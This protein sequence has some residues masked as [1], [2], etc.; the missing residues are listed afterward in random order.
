VR[1]TGVL[2]DEEAP[3]RWPV[4]AAD[5]S[6]SSEGRCGML[7]AADSVVGTAVSSRYEGPVCPSVTVVIPTANRA[8]LLG[9]LFS[10][11]EDQAYPADR[12]EVVVVDDGSHD[13]TWEVLTAAV[14]ETQMRALAVRLGRNMGQGEARNVGA[15]LA[16]GEVLAFTDDDC[17]PSA[18]WLSELLSPFA[19]P[20]GAR[21][22]VQGRTTPWD[23]DA[24]DAGP[25]ARTVWVLR[26]TWLFETCN[27]AYRRSDFIDAGGFVRRHEVPTTRSG[28]LIGEDAVLGWR[29]M[30]Q[31]A[32]LFFAPLAQVRHRNF[33]ATYAQW[34]ASHTGKAAF[35]ALVSASPLARRAL[36][37][38]YFLA[39]RTA[40]FDLALAGIAAAVLTRRARW[41]QLAGP[42]VW[43]ALPEAAQRPGRHP[44]VRLSQIA[45]GDLVGFAS[46]VV[47]SL[48]AGTFVG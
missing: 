9:V 2:A 44:V 35:P 20:T 39:P 14:G 19:G 16:R 21:I 24:E 48:R 46:L 40:A 37:A 12:F 36:W 27:V 30:E 6:S 10:S 23:E 1:E 33:R 32:D 5:S 25:W 31:G 41:C 3:V 42:W 45:L 26:K 29:V 11:L 17:V 47:G 43:L 7:G 28:K 18:S 13:D 4:V 15:R 38:R 34:L 8:G 22:V